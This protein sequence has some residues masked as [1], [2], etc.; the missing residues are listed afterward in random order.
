MMNPE[1][2]VLLVA[3]QT[4][5]AL[6][7]RVHGMEVEHARAR[8][9]LAQLHDE[10]L[11]DLLRGGV[12]GAALVLGS[13]LTAA[14]PHAPVDEALHFAALDDQAQRDQPPHD[15]AAKGSRI[16]RCRLVLLH[17]VECMLREL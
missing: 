11:R 3:Q 8:I 4:R 6:P 15:E 2:V 5:D 10:S 17:E 14:H 1:S 16:S 12:L 9:C 7:L 13:M